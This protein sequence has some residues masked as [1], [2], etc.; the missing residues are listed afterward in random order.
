MQYLQTKPPVRA[1]TCLGDP[2]GVA[3]EESS[4]LLSIDEKLAIFGAKSQLGS[5]G[6]RGTIYLT[7]I[8]PMSVYVLVSWGYLVCGVY[9]SVG[10]CFFDMYFA[11]W[12]FP[13]IPSRKRYNVILCGGVVVLEPVMY[14]TGSFC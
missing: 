5:A 3:G 6:F 2:I 8:P 13:G 12:A 4:E 9:R 10:L 11:I 14:L 1:E 7:A